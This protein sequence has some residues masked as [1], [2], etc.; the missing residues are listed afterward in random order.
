MIQLF[1]AISTDIEIVI[2]TQIKAPTNLY[3][4]VNIIM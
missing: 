2:A 1:L 3:C 4:T